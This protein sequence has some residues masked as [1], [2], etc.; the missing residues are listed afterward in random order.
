MFNWIFSMNIFFGKG[1]DIIYNYVNCE[2]VV[3]DYLKFLFYLKYCCKVKIKY[4]D[5]MN[6]FLIFIMISNKE[7]LNLFIF[8]GC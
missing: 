1:N 6:V 4:G 5:Y 8:L 2:N 3:C 7:N